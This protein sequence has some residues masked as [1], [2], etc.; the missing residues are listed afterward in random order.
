MPTFLYQANYSS[1]AVK[2]LVKNPQDRTAAVQGIVAAVGGTLH[3]C[4]LSFGKHDIVVIAEAKDDS[5][6]AAIAMAVAAAGSVV[7]GRVTRL[8]SMSDGES[9]MK[10]AQ[11]VLA[12]YAKPAGN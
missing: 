10:Q 7:N 11:T 1:D 3:G 8:M 5:A 9:A 2:A 6:M 4:W 12:G